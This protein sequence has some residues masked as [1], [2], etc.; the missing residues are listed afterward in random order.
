MH[1]HTVYLFFSEE[2]KIE[3]EL[4]SED[5]KKSN[6]KCIANIPNADKV[7]Q[8]AKDDKATG[9]LIVSDNFL[10]SIDETKHLEKLLDKQYNNQIIPVLT[11]GRRPKE[12]YP[13]QME[14]YP[15]KI[16]TLNN[17]MYYRDYWY[18]KWINLRKMAKNANESEQ[19][20]FNIK[21]DIAKKMS[22]GSIST[23]I[24]QINN[25]AV[26]DWDSF[27]SDGY[28]SFFEKIGLDNKGILENSDLNGNNGTKPESLDE[29]NNDAPENTDA[30]TIVSAENETSEM[31]TNQDNEDDKTVLNEDKEDLTLT[32]KQESEK[33]GLNDTEDLTAD[34]PAE[35][36][37]EDMEIDNINTG[38]EN[39]EL[40]ETLS[41][42]KEKEIIDIDVLFHIAESKAEEGEYEESKVSYENILQ[43]D[44]YN[45]RALIGLARLLSTYYQD[46]PSLSI[47]AY[48]KAIMVNDENAD[49]YFEYAMLQKDSLKAYNKASDSFREALEINPSFEDAYLG[50]AFCQKEMGMPLQAKAN[51]L[52]ACVLNADLFQTVENDKHFAVVRAASA[53][54][55]SGD[56]ASEEMEPQRSPNADTVVMVT[57]ASSGIG[58]SIAQ[59]FIING[60]K[61]IITARR[62]ERLENLKKEMESEFEE[63][64]IYCLPFDVCNIE[65]VKNALSILPEDWSGVDILINNAGLAKGFAPV[66]E[67]NIEHWEAMIN[68]NVKGLLYMSRMITPGMVERKKG[69]IVNLS[70]VA[71]TQVYSGGGAYCA[72][73]AAVDSLTR[74]MRLD[75]YK[76]NIKVSSISPGHV[77]STEFAAV[78]YDDESKNSI[79]SDFKPLN[80]QDIAETIYYVVSR[81]AHVN[82]Q[83]VL[84]FGTQQASARDVDRSGRDDK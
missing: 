6:I 46:E 54:D 55:I 42:N 50:L 67:G 43:I 41:Q 61:V 78:R 32:E 27:C 49:L 68:T 56:L 73:K 72:T 7:T 21:K 52:Q 33:P 12:G 14:V 80:A 31:D 8:I 28:Q 38:S 10:K 76:H 35:K 83:D 63:T 26:I 84:I 17:V 29:T 4:L 25:T 81:P 70:S 16:K 77:D 36:T 39:K 11:H 13:D 58:K 18:E 3:A 57:G 34:T 82:I 9:L 37:N 5:F 62:A 19:E 59:Q 69:H 40:K 45:G 74:S 2:N 20:E 66:Q 15:T 1:N 51:Y 47:N 71:G 60:Y 44:M 24:R 48:R 65:A 23:Y 30:E 22:V 75:L 53:E 64:Q 79:Y